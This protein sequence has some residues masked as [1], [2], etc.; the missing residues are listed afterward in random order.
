[1]N[2]RPF[3]LAAAAACA[4]MAAVAAGAADGSVAH[5]VIFKVAPATVTLSPGGRAEATITLEIEKGCRLIAAGSA[6]RFAEPAL[7]SFDAADGVFA[8]VPAWP[9]G[10]SWRG[11]ESD[12]EMKVYEGLLKL[13]VTLGAAPKAPPQDLTLRGRL[14]YQVIRGDMFEKVAVLPVSIPVKVAAPAAP[15]AKGAT[16]R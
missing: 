3:R 14:R 9:A 16:R 7:L 5:P 10:T 13:K 12:P 6:H 4:T 1:M 11:D 2:R 15:P 8:Q